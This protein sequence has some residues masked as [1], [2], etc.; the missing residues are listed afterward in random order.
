MGTRGAVTHM[1][2]RA[3]GKRTVQTITMKPDPAQAEQEQLSPRFLA[4]QI[5]FSFLKLD[6]TMSPYFCNL[7]P[8]FRH[9]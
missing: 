7:T 3:A 4:Q 8:I 1:K 5:I 9:L 2:H 6:Q